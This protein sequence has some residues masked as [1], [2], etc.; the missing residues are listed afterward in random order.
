MEA[1][2]ELVTHVTARTVKKKDMTNADAVKEA[3]MTVI[4]GEIT[5]IKF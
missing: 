3:I 2:L 5:I 4:H 1:V